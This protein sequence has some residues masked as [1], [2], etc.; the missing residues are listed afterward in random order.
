M[1]TEPTTKK[2]KPSEILKVLKQDKTNSESFKSEW[3]TKRQTYHNEWAGRPY[4]NEVKGKSAVVSRDIK[5]AQIWQHSS[6]KDPFVNST[7]AVK[8]TPVGGEDSPLSI[9]TAEVLNYQYSREF[10]RYRFITSALKVFQV[11]GTVV[12]RVFWTFEEKEIEVE[13]PVFET[14][15][16]MGPQGPV[17][18]PVPVGT[19]MVKK[20][21]T[22][23]NHPD[24]RVV[25]I[26]IF[27]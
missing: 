13:E 27:G 11:E 9:Q 21:V 18:Q 2:L 10:N 23:K 16:I 20:T 26:K 25:K 6:L 17:A 7:D 8:T 15:I 19:Q 12:A 3:D 22:V 5:L 24:A 14:Q 1:T 4:G